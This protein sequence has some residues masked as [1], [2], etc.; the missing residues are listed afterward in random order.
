MLVMTDLTL[1][2]EKVH[3]YFRPPSG[4]IGIFFAKESLEKRAARLIKRCFA[5]R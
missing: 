1:G 5:S 3:T 4:K 2:A